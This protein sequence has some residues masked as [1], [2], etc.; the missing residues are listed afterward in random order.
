[1]PLLEETA[2]QRGKRETSAFANRRAVLFMIV[3]AP[4][5]GGAGAILFSFDSI[6]LRALLGA[7][8][9][10]LVAVLIP[11]GMAALFAVRAP[12]RQRDD[13]RDYAL[14][15]EVYAKGLSQRADRLQIAD[16]FRRDTL[17]FARAVFEGN[18]HRPA[19]EL[20]TQWRQN[21]SSMRALLL[22]RGAG[23]GV[24]A[25]FDRQLE[26]LDRKDDG[27][28]DDEIRRLAANMQATCQNVWSLVRN[29]PAPTAPPPPRSETR[30]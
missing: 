23:D 29:E 6:V 30:S 2:W 10:L 17:D 16:D 1:V 4:A 19:S 27:Y 13:A 21:A 14:A 7:L 9:G 15:L 24:A 28:G 25:E 3:C 26:A 5:F 22:D 8:I 11:L 18:W 20:D 12:Y